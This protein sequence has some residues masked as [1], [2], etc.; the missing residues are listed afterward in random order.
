METFRE[1]N[2]SV[3]HRRCGSR[4]SRAF[5]RFA[6]ISVRLRLDYICCSTCRAE[7]RFDGGCAAK[8]H[9]F[10]AQ[11]NDDRRASATG[12][13]GL[14][15]GSASNA[16]GVPG[17]LLAVHEAIARAARE[18]GRSSVDVTLVCVSKTFPADAIRP[19]LQ[20]GERVF[21]ENRV[22]E[23]RSKWPE[24]RRDFPDARLHLIGPL[25]TNKVREAIEFFDVIETVDRPKLARAIADEIQ[26]SGRSPGLFIEVNTGAEP[27]KAGVS[28]PD[29]DA[30]IRHCRDE[31][32]LSIEGLMCIPPEHEQSSPHFSL[33]ATIARRNGLRALSM[34]MSADFE[35]AIQA[36]ATHVRIGSAIFGARTGGARKADLHTGAS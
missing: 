17:R 20:L 21:G 18:S 26:R 23:A 10:E 12:G 8:S 29:A 32:G 24:L 30:F 3:E 15:V 33:L 11:V 13:Q 4:K 2:T 7:N 27:Q 22:Q 25:Q 31:L 28:P 6:A 35:L 1:H 14:S 16:E 34:G 36:G 5:P 19:A 9:C